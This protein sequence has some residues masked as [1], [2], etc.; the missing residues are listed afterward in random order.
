MQTQQQPTQ[1][2][3]N[4][5]PNARKTV[6]SEIS[7][8]MQKGGIPIEL[9]SVAK[10]GTGDKT[11]SFFSGNEDRSNYGHLAHYGL[12]GKNP[13][14]SQKGKLVGFQVELH[15]PDMAA[16]NLAG[17]G[18]YNVLDSANKLINMIR[19]KITKN[20]TVLR[21]GSFKSIIDPLPRVLK[22]FKVGTGIE[23][24][25]IAVNAVQTQTG[26]IE[27]RNSGLRV[28]YLPVDLANNDSFV[29]DAWLPSQGTGVD[30]PLNN[31]LLVVTAL[32]VEFPK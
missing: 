11:F 7:L 27:E 25:L 8:L 12:G 31:H 17:D 26:N 13:I 16:L 24:G 18:T 1:A 20:K 15:G 14:E 22:P 29:F 6:Q 19:F 5:N 23:N 32:G 2:R 9:Q 28:L 21:E 3:V 30:L 4:K 10:L